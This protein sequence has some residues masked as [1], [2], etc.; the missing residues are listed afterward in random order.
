MPDIPGLT[1]SFRGL[2]IHS[3]NYRRAEVF[4]DMDVVV[5]G[6]GFS[7]VDICLNLTDNAHKIYFSHKN[8]MFQD[9]KFPSNIEQVSPIQ[10][11]TDDG[12]VQFTDGQTRR[13]DAILL[14]TG[15][16]YSFPFLSPECH[17]TVDLD[18]KR[19]NTLYKDVFHPE[20]P[21]LSFV[22]ILTR[23]LVFQLFAI[24]MR[25]IVA[26]LSE[27]ACLPSHDEMEEDIARER[28][29]LD[30]LGWPAHHA[31]RRGF[32]RRSY[33]ASLAKLAG[34]PN[35]DPL[36]DDILDYNL[37]ALSHNAMKFK[38]LEIYIKDSNTFFVAQK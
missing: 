31:H 34:C 8:Q 7:G 27:N 37:A 23:A 22:G 5:L 4:Q 26:V 36:I 25:C 32:M 18:G 29:K 38:D 30:L 9:T 33:C 2:V 20:H 1:D 24:Q 19:V 14:C 16:K 28:E 3:H 11:V 17:V 6:G 35:I 15:Y 13:A 10:R 21:S 12:T